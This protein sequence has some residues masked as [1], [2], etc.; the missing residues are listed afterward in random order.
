MDIDALAAKY[1]GVS[2]AV[3]TRAKENQRRAAARAAASTGTDLASPV[4]SLIVAGR[5]LD[6][7]LDAKRLAVLAGVSARAVDSSVQRLLVVVG[8]DSVVRTTPAALCIRFGCEAIAEIV[9]RVVAEYKRGARLRKPASR[10]ADP[11][12]PVFVAA[13]L[14]ACSKQANVS[15]RVAGT[16]PRVV[17]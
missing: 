13:C 10:D 4:A 14:Y 16:S 2:R 5:A 9:G 17:V 1:G 7:P 3:V 15:P 12:E 6:E 8:A 11:K